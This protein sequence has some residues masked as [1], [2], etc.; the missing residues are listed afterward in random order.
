MKLREIK[1]KDGS[2][3]EKSDLVTKSFYQ[4]LGSVLFTKS[5]VVCLDGLFTKSLV[6]CMHQICGVAL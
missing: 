2:I 6:V 1:S 3:L 4:E 5:L